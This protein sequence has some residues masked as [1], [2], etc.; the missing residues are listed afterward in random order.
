MM[1]TI[2]N[3]VPSSNLLG[4]STADDAM[5]DGWLSFIWTSLDV[6]LKV[7]SDD[8]TNETAKEDVMKAFET[9]ETY[10]SSRKY[11]VGDTLTLA[12]ISLALSLMVATSG[13]QV[14]YGSVLSEWL[15]MITSQIDNNN[16]ATTINTSVEG[17]VNGVMLNGVP[18]SVENKLY[19]RHRIRIKELLANDGKNYVNQTVTVA[20]WARTTRN[21]NKGQLLFV[22]LNDGSTGESLQCVLDAEKTENFEE[23]KNCGGTGASF[24]M[25]GTLI[26]SQGEGQTVEVA[27]TTGKL[28]G[29]VYGGDLEGT[30]IGG[31]LYAMSK[32][33]HTLEYMRENAHLR[34]RGRVHAAVMRIRHAMAYA[35]HTFFHNHGFLYIHTPILTG[36]DCEGAGE[37]FAV[38]TLLGSDHLQP[39]V[40]LPVHEP[41]P[42]SK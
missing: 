15:Q 3:I 41:P 9:V 2:A 8:T 18:P 7:L 33:A 24:Q 13:D 27:V 38:T 30:S 32:K 28:L 14:L 17:G 40:T 36:A 11:M 1:R 25:V 29:A 26:P 23:C 31:K 35:T 34:P 39:G 16:D 21:A 4:T 12:D 20:G 19:R 6:P 10:M 42:V 37:Q 22:E 5:I